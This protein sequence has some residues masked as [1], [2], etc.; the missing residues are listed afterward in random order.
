MLKKV[1]VFDSGIGGLSVAKSVLDHKLF[2][3]LI[4][5][6]DTARV[7]YGSKDKNTIIRYALEAVE[8][9]K[10][11]DI[12]MLIVACNSVSAYAI[13]EMRDIA[14]FKVIGVIESGVEATI[15]KSSKDDNIMIIGTHATINSDLY[16]QNLQDNGYTHT[17]S[18]ATPLLVSIVEEELNNTPILK[19][20]LS[21]YFKNS[22][23]PDALIL[24]CTH[25]PFIKK[26]LNEYFPNT[27]L[28]HSGDA[29]VEHLI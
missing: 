4:Y 22:P 23:T 7:P 14:P 16:N 27:K 11:F 17:T 26:E 15:S 2:S 28:I 1:G 29:I 12:D 6:G 20:T 19:E 24:G 25:F 3:E 18:I 5:Y 8:F 13:D 21:H 10:N 9:F